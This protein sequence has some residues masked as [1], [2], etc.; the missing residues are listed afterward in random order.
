MQTIV[1]FVQATIP[2]PQPKAPAGVEKQASDMMAYVKWGSLFVII[3]SG[4]IGAAALIG[5]KWL[6]HHKSAQLGIGLLLTAIA[7]AIVW[8]GI[9]GFLTAIT[10]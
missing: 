8:A 3:I 9:Y 6:T 7:A 1:H 2:N 4:F 5:G 10:G